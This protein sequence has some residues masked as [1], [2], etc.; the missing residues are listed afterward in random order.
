[1]VVADMINMVHVETAAEI[2][3]STVPRTLLTTIEDTVVPL[4]IP[5]IS[6]SRTNNGH[7]IILNR[8]MAAI[9]QVID[10][11]KATADKHTIRLPVGAHLV[12]A[13]SR[14]LNTTLVALVAV[15]MDQ[16][17]GALVEITA[18]TAAMA[19]AEETQ[20]EAVMPVMVVTEDRLSMDMVAMAVTVHHTPVAEAGGAINTSQLTYEFLLEDVIQYA[21]K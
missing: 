20:V 15:V 21:L 9:T 1:M 12:E 3:C 18:D 4:V 5:L 11:H 14:A 13:V 2:Q 10:R 16:P 19:L 8:D 7:P 6:N 17:M